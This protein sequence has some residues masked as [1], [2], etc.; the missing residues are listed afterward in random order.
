MAQQRQSA[1][2]T[3]AE[4]LARLRGAARRTTLAVPGSS[5]KMLAKATGLAADEV[6]LDLEDAV[7]GP[8]K[9]EARGNIVAALRAGGFAAGQV[10]VRVNAW[11]TPD[12]VYDVVEILGGIG[13]AQLD[14]I[15]LPKVQT[16]AQVAALDLVLSQAEQAAGRLVGAIGIQP[17]IEDAA[18]LTAID[19]IAAASPRVVSLV[20]GPGD[21][22]ASL[23]MRSLTV[24]AQPEGLACGDA[25]HYPLAKILVAARAH[26]IQAIDGPYVKVRDVEGFRAAAAHSAAL[27]FDG[28]WV[29][30]PDQVAAGNEVFSPR[31]DDV[32]RAHEI[33]TAYAA[34]TSVAGGARGAIMVGDEMVDEAG[35]KMALVVR[36]KARAAGIWPGE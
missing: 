1:A 17:Q 30:H 3:R 12:T 27:G 26:G 35:R 15:I 9:A 4:A 2:S 32:D 33:L 13:A 8:A 20:F 23:G 14:S 19:E 11:D 34:S 22:M 6:F 31:P 21:F 16:A 5:P 7:A 10:C 25:Y 24:G 18:G 36:Q 29:L 28:K